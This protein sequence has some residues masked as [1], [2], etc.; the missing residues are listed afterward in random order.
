VTRFDIEPEYGPDEYPAW[1]DWP[2]TGP[3]CPWPREDGERCEHGYLLTDPDECPNN[4]DHAVDR[5][6]EFASFERLGERMSSR[7]PSDEEETEA[8]FWAR[9]PYIPDDYRY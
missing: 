1:H 2:V 5:E 3:T 4:R 7:W 6:A 9:Q 8:E